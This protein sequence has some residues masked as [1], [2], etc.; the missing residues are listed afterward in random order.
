MLMLAVTV[1]VFTPLIGLG[2]VGGVSLRGSVAPL[3]VGVIIGA[4]IFGIGMQLGGGCASGT[5]FTVGGGNARMIITLAAFITGGFG[6]MHRHCRQLR[7]RQNSVW[8]A[9]L[10][11]A[12]PFSRWFGLPVRAGRNTNTVI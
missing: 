10:L 11:L 7:F 3:S 9:L 12:W 5:L 4:F 8:L 6:R 1:L 2:E